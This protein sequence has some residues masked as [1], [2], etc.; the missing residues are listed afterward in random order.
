M[1]T[2]LPLEETVKGIKNAYIEATFPD[3]KGGA[4]HQVGRGS[5][6]S[7]KAAIARA[8]S[9]LLKQPKLRRK[10]VRSIQARIT[11]TEAQPQEET[12]VQS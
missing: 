5:G 2:T 12:N 1:G 6:G 9:D 3:M 10:H 4:A 7:V 8:F 11:I